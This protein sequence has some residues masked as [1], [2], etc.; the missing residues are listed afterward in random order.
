MELPITMALG[1]ILGFTNIGVRAIIYKQINQKKT[2]SLSSL[3][4]ELERLLNDATHLVNKNK[5][6]FMK[7]IA[8]LYKLELLLR[9]T[10]NYMRAVFFGSVLIMIGVFIIEF[11]NMSLI[12]LVIGILVSEIGALWVWFSFID[13]NSALEIIEK[14]ERGTTPLEIVKNMKIRL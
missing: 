7:N 12:P 1:V 10:D 13:M 6:E 2:T 9:Q 5:R 4:T 3:T 11:T 14:M 8:G